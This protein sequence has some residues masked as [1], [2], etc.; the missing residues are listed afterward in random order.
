MLKLAGAEL[1]LEDR[2]TRTGGTL[3]LKPRSFFEDVLIF[4][5]MRT[6]L[7]SVQAKR[8]HPDLDCGLPGRAAAAFS[9]AMGLAFPGLWAPRDL[10][11]QRTLARWDLGSSAHQDASG[12]RSYVHV[13]FARRAP[14]PPAAAPPP[15]EA[16]RRKR[17]TT[18][19][20]ER[21]RRQREL[22]ETP[23]VLERR[24]RE[25]QRDRERLQRWRKKER[26]LPEAE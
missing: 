7:S 6:C 18:L 14:P 5:F 4:C 11:V 22:P 2:H 17:K 19:E 1:A 3:I 21:R 10:R 26:E 25:R 24:E 16:E 15:T 12:K 20:R 13:I 8:E 9:E 23:E